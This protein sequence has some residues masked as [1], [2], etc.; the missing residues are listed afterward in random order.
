MFP[1]VTIVF[2]D[3]DYYVIPDRQGIVAAHCDFYWLLLALSR[4][5]AEFQWQ[6]SMPTSS[7][8]A[9]MPEP[10][11]CTTLARNREIAR[12]IQPPFFEEEVMVLSSLRR[13]KTINLFR[14]MVSTLWFLDSTITV[15][16]ETGTMDSFTVTMSTKHWIWLQAY[17]A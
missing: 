8:I 9:S 11:S 15:L 3:S 6:L 10:D 12:L 17:R 14:V 2:Y 5:I 7:L 1:T 4:E 13:W 16:F